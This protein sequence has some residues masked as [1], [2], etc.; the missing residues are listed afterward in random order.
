MLQITDQTIFGRSVF[1]NVRL[2]LGTRASALAR[3]QANWARERLM[4]F[5]IEV[6]LVPIST[7]GDR[8]RQVP[9]GS[10]GGQGVFT[11]ELQQLQKLLLY[12]QHKP[13]VQ[14][15]V[16]HRTVLLL[17]MSSILGRWQQIMQQ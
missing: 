9:I 1:S 12:H 14:M 3:W 11:K 2:R 5:D 4:E 10:V 15:L 13:L 8:Q 17:E 16:Q 6:S 7:H